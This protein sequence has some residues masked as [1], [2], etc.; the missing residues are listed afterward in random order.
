MASK[1][2]YEADAKFLLSKYLQNE[3][4]VQNTVARV[5]EST[6]LDAL[7]EQNAW[8]SQQVSRSTICRSS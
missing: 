3:K 6:Q 1:A 2:I 8:L 5:N 4:L 7:L